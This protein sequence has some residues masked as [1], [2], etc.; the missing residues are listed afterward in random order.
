MTTKLCDDSG[1]KLMWCDLLAN[2]QMPPAGQ[3]KRTKDL[4]HNHRK[5]IPPTAAAAADFAAFPHRRQ[6]LPADAFV[7]MVVPK[8]E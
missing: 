8:L 1:K 7:S 2:K 5:I 3:K 6:P 4:P